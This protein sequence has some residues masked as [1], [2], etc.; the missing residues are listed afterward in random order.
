M[1]KHSEKDFAIA[2]S[3]LLKINYKQYLL[4]IKYFGSLEKAYYA[5]KDY[6]LKFGWDS[7]NL[8]NFLKKRNLMNLDEIRSVVLIE[9]IKACFVKDDD[10]PLLLSKIYDPPLVFFYKGSLNIDWGRSLSVVGSRKCTDYGRKIIKDYVS[11]LSKNNLVIVSGLA[12]GI[13]SLSHKEALVNKGR[14]VA[15]LGSGLDRFSVYPRHNLDLFDEIINK[16][17]LIISEFPAKTKPLSSN[18]PQRNRIIAGL[19]NHLIV[20]EAE[21]RSGSLITAKYALDEGREVI[22]FPGSVYS[23][24]SAGTNKLIKDGALSITGFDDLKDITWL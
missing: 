23:K 11:F 8:H 19:S 24:N 5:K 7:N 18:F 14:T 21:K 10:Y 15:V 6:F 2:F 22:A 20:V 13:D 9:G 4:L 17:G 12:T 16:N 3:F 1:K